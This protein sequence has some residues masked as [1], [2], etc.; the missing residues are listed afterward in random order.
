MHVSHEGMGNGSSRAVIPVI[1]IGLWFLTFGPY[2]KNSVC[3][4]CRE[5]GGRKTG[6]NKLQTFALMNSDS[7]VKTKLDLKKKSQ[8]DIQK[9]VNI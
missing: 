1:W 7:H 4:H 8:I 3:F 9:K 2:H 6:D 5:N